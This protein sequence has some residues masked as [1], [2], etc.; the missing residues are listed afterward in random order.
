MV[1][2]NEEFCINK[3][4]DLGIIYKGYY[5]DKKKG[6]MIKYICE[7]HFDKGIQTIDWSHFKI[8][9]VDCYKKFA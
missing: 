4:K 5:K 6:T 9:N 2:F 1:E 3:C 8:N 7:K